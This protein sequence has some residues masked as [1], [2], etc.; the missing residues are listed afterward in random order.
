LF[1]WVPYFFAIQAFCFYIPSWI[2]HFLQQYG[3]HRSTINSILVVDIQTVVDEAVAIRDER[4]EE[5][6]SK[7]LVKV[8]EFIRTSFEYR[9]KL[10]QSVTILES[11]FENLFMS[12]CASL[13]KPTRLGFFATAA[14]LTTKFVWLINDAIQLWLIGRF[15]G[16]DDPTWA[17]QP[18]KVVQKVTNV[19]SKTAIHY[20]PR[21]TF[22]DIERHTLGR[23]QIDTF[24]CVLMLNVI[25]E[26]LF[27]MLW[28]WI[29]VVSVWLSFAVGGDVDKFHLY[30]VA[31]RFTEFAMLEFHVVPTGNLSL[32]LDI[33]R[34]I[35]ATEH[36]H[37]YFLACGKR[38][39][40]TFVEN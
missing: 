9:D 25:N 34:G 24:Q 18:S 21:V 11:L 6:R 40:R 4:K 35:D 37:R 5:N 20:F 22:C 17:F 23:M 30:A 33:L 29:V 15:L 14:Y 3:R 39:I 12:F 26:K 7:K 27:V 10:Q 19:G 31:I 32:N 1:Q 13:L 8:V 38:N 2:W 28:F 36:Q 16:I